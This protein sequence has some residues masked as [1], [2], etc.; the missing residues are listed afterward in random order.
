MLN[1]FEE[2]LKS[3][4]KINSV[5]LTKQFTFNPLILIS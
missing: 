3:T 1:G 2:I 5:F 4:L